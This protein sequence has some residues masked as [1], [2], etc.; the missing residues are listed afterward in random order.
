VGIDDLLDRALDAGAS[1]LHIT[2]GAPPCLRVDGQLRPLREFGVLTARDTGA[3]VAELLDD[4]QRAAFGRDLDLDTTH[5]TDRARFRVSVFRQ[6]SCV[7]AV[8]RAIPTTVQPLASLGLPP[9]VAELAALPRGLVLVTGPTGSGKSTT[10]AALVD[11]VN[12]TRSVH[13]VTVEGP[14]EFLHR[15]KRSI[16]NQRQ[17]GDD[18]LSFANALRHALRQDPDVLLVGELRDLDTIAMAV[19]AAETG[20][21][22]FATLH[23]QD[24]PQSVDRMIDVFPAHQQAQVRV[25]LAASLQAVV[26]QQLVPAAD[27]GRA[28]ACEVLVATPAVRA[29]V[30]EGKTHQLASTMQASARFGMVTMDQSLARLV[31][32]GTITA[33]AAG[34]RAANV[35]DFRRLSGMAVAG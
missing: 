35:D 13:I 26:T 4:D 3:L 6:R 23:T 9:V 12:E 30:R 7:G 10:L 32:D 14:I 28:L 18:T 34:E 5:T 31:R 1:D 19:T 24:A 29:L 27:G 20:H 25:Q 16:V 2:V 11:H 15:N 17:V 8:L 22:V 33:G 21:L